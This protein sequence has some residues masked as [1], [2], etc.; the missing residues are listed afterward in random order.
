MTAR[1][2]V[3]VVL[4][5]GSLV[6]LGTSLRGA[7]D[8]VAVL[9]PQDYLEYFAAGRAVLHGQNPYDGSVI[10]AHQ[11]AVES[12]LPG[13]L[14]RTEPVMMWNPPYVLPL[15][16]IL[17]SM[18]WRAGQLLWL[19]VNLAAV[20]QAAVW[21]GNLYLPAVRN[22]MLPVLLAIAFAPTLY[23]ML[24]GQISGVLLLGLAGFAW[25]Q[26]K[27]QWVLAGLFAALTAIKPHLFAPFALV[28]VLQASTHRG[29]RRAVFAGG[30]ALLVL[31]VVPTL[32]QPTVWVHFFYPSVESGLHHSVQE[33][34]NPTLGYLVRSVWPGQPFHAVFLPL[35]IAIPAVGVWWMVNRR[36]W[37]WLVEL[38]RLVL[39]GLIAAPYGAWM[40]D[41]VVLLVPLM[42]LAGALAQ[43]S[44]TLLRWK[45]IMLH[46]VMQLLALLALREPNSVCNF[47]Y[48][49]ATA[50]PYLA[51]EARRWRSNAQATCLPRPQ[52]VAEV[53]R[54]G[55][56]PH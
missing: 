41:L 52:L 51:L 16:M 53:A 30:A 38:P 2:L 45:C 56:S 39:V 50:I 40:F 20:V 14:Q 48:V 49:W 28:L 47:W 23:L 7:W 3:L 31:S 34:M 4:L 46:A 12:G 26:Q 17:G 32:W 18:P 19:L 43:S 54:S 11:Q 6:A 35:L 37:N 24:L 10:F 33:W 13:D 44:S 27:Q 8:D 22:R 15:A 29:T 9:R 36:I 42:P 1:V 25:F 21:L 5:A 55:P